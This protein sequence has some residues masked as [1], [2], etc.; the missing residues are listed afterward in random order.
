MGLATAHARVTQTRGSGFATRNTRYTER[1]KLLRS[2]DVLRDLGRR[3]AELRTIRGLTQDRLAENADVT[4][5]YIQRI[6]A[7]REN[8]TVRSLVRIANLLGASVPELFQEP[9]RRQVRPGRPSK[10]SVQAPRLGD[11]LTRDRR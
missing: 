2:D 5:Q 9:L 11:R 10:P 4:V 7:G 1:V 6:E 8:L 3:I